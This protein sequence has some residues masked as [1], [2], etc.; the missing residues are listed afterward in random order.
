[1]RYVKL[2]ATPVRLAVVNAAQRAWAQRQGRETVTFDIAA[3][4]I[5][6][7]QVD[8]GLRC[9]VQEAAFLWP[10]ISSPLRALHIHTNE[11]VFYVLANGVLVARQESLTTSAVA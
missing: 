8:E 1:M 9:R 4:S 2:E 3:R 10:G 5:G 6:R 7:K 11:E